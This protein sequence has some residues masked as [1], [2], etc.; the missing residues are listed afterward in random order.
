MA[1]ELPVMNVPEGFVNFW[2]MD[3]ETAMQYFDVDEDKAQF[4]LN[5]FCY[6][7][8]QNCIER[9][10]EEILERVLEPEQFENY[11]QSKDFY[12]EGRLIKDYHNQL[13]QI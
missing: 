5:H 2:S 9:E 4:I 10:R 12:F 6:S 3:T 7:I 13:N 8:M 1:L 11:L